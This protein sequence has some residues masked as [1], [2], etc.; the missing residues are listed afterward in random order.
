[1]A[2]NE[3]ILVEQYIS[4]EHFFTDVEYINLPI[5][6]SWSDAKL[7]LNSAA[8]IGNYSGSKVF[9]HLVVTVISNR[10]FQFN[11]SGAWGH[12]LFTP[13]GFP[14]TDGAMFN[15]TLEPF[16]SVHIPLKFARYVGWTYNNPLKRPYG[17]LGVEWR[18][19]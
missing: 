13:D 6:D 15:I 5:E 12:V 4:Y 19:I 7:F 14:M 2:V 8:S 3:V 10:A 17:Q 16:I 1:V 18:P 9:R 11:D